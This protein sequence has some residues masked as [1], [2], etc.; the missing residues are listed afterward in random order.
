M[1]LHHF[2]SLLRKQL[3][4][5]LEP[6]GHREFTVFAAAGTVFL[7][8]ALLLAVLSGVEKIECLFHIH[9]MQGIAGKG[10]LLRGVFAENEPPS[11]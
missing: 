9:I 5:L 4:D 6:G 7:S 11:V 3:F 2:D 1:T 8:D 10:E